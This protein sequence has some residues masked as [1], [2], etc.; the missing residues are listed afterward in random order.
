MAEPFAITTGDPQFKPSDLGE[1]LI[2]LGLARRWR[3]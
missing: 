2:G 3:K 1:H